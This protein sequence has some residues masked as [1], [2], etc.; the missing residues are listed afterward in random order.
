[1]LDPKLPVE[2]NTDH[3]LTTNR[4]RIRGLLPNKN[5]SEKSLE[6]WLSH[7]LHRQLN[8]AKYNHRLCTP[9]YYQGRVSINGPSRLDQ[10]L[11]DSRPTDSAPA[12]AV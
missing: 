7:E 11:I 5:I 12:S 6:T 10:R 4:Q 3:I 2:V 8:A 9:Q 1:M